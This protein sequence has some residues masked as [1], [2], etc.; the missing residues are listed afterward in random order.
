M[1]II[2]NDRESQLLTLTDITIHRKLE[3]QEN[4]NHMLTMM[5]ANIHHEIVTPLK[6]NINVAEKLSK[7]KDV[8]QLKEMA[9]IVSVSSKLV[10][11]HANDMLDHRLI[12]VGNFAPAYSFSSLEKALLEIVEM[13]RWT[14]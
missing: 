12:Q 8:S 3:Q 10:L 9:Q 7:L 14:I 13:M 11:F 4:K 2:F 5:N 1:E 6:V